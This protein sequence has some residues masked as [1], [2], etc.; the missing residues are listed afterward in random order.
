MRLGLL[1][2]SSIVL[3]L[4]ST[5]V[6]AT[7]TAETKAGWIKHKV[8]PPVLTM[9]LTLLVFIALLVFAL[10]NLMAI[11]TPVMFADKSL[12]LNKEY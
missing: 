12:V 2:S 4:I 1:D 10:S 5:L 7:A 9:I 8:T 11:K 3:L 6:E